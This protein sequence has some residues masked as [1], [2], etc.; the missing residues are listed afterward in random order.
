MRHSTFRAALLAAALV[1]AGGIGLAAAQ[2][3][4]GVYDPAQLPAVKGKVA[5]YDLTSRGD[6][7][8]LI[9]EDGTEVHFPPHLGTEVVAV[10][11]P[12]DAV[13]VHGLKAR[14]LPLVQAMSVTADASGKTVED[15][16]PP[17]GAPPGG[18]MHGPMHEH[19]A[20]GGPGAMMMMHGGPGGPGWMMGRGTPATAQGTIKAQL[21]GPRG[22]LNGV[23]L[24]DGTIVRMPPPA[25]ARL[26]DQ[27]K[28]GQPI[29]VEGFGFTNNLGKL[30]LARAIGPSPDHLTEIKGP[31]RP[32]GHE[33]PGGPD[34]APV[35]PDAPL[36]PL[37]R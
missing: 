34:G 29:A 18:P 32:M 33:G 25:A 20:M 1:T 31:P 7:D 2:S 15:N 8:G 19:G 36:T 30:V 10:V 24:T 13:T 17:G 4:I 37:S 3:N 26:E 6:V 12:G 23:L 11:K 27:I 5:Q 9:L 21:H 35:A 14:S 16:G 22:D 28:P